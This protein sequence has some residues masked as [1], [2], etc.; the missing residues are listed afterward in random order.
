MY[1]SN[2]LNKKKPK[3][4]RHIF[5]SNFVFDLSCVDT[6]KLKK[7]FIRTAFQ[8]NFCRGVTPFFSKTS[9]ASVKKAKFQ[10]VQLALHCSRSSIRPL[11]RRLLPDEVSK[12][13]ANAPSRFFNFKAKTN[14][15]PYFLGKNGGYDFLPLDLKL[16]SPSVLYKQGN[17]SPLVLT[18]HPSV[19]KDQNTRNFFGGILKKKFAFF[20]KKPLVF[21]RVISEVFNKAIKKGCLCKKASGKSGGS[22]IAAFKKP[23]KAFFNLRASLSSLGL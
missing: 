15:A 9:F 20:L 13:P 5:T 23:K 6:F 18:N 11:E 10:T 16:N 1:N 7:N 4:I 14:I 17:Q 2:I 22:L 19:G 12:T 3:V 21:I 8:T